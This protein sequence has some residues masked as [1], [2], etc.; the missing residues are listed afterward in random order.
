LLLITQLHQLNMTKLLHRTKAKKGYFFENDDIRIDIKYDDE[1]IQ[2]ELIKITPKG[3]DHA[4]L[5][6]EDLLAIVQEQFKQKDLAAALTTADTSFVPTAEAA[7][8]IYFNAS[9]DIKQGELVQFFA[10]M[11]IPLGIALVMEANRLCE[12]KGKEILKIP[13]EE[14]EEAKVT[15]QEQAKE[16]TE[17]FF[18]PQL[19]AL[20][21]ARDSEETKEITN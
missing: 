13:V 12:I 5:S 19:D 15:L 6:S 11:H 21:K 2:R 7:V 16:F 10:P 8:P 1:A 14:F 20:K 18:K 4:V 17:K 3:K 9:K